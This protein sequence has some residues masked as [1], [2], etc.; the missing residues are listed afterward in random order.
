MS[1]KTKTIIFSSLALAIL[2]AVIIIFHVYRSADYR[3]YQTVTK[4]E[5][6]NH[7]GHEIAIDILLDLADVDSLRAHLHDIPVISRQLQE[8]LPE[9]SKPAELINMEMSFVRLERVV[10]NLSPGQPIAPPLLE[11]VRNEIMKISENVAALK[12]LTEQKINTLHARANMMIVV[13]FIALVAYISGI[14]LFLFRM[15]ITP[16]LTFSD[17][18]EQIREGQ[19]ENITLPQRNDEL[20]QLARVFI[21][22]IDKRHQVEKEL[23]QEVTEHK[24]ALDKVKLLSGFLPIC[25]SCK[26][27]RDDRGYW[28]QIESYIRDNSEVEFS[29]GICPECADK[30]YGNLLK[31]KRER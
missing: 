21:Q 17:Q 27:V 13:L 16:L 29:H 19:L 3:L 14:F 30:L 26:Q 12:N 11:Q 24:Q 18:V 23:K 10:D 28:N 22:L 25:A 1:L 4:L 20:G 2:I 31:K 7:A 5:M 15:I 8:I 9:A 6:I